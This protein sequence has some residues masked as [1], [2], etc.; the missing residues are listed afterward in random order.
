MEDKWTDLVHHAVDYLLFFCD[1]IIHTSIFSNAN[2]NCGATGKDYDIS[3]L[4]RKQQLQYVENIGIPSDS[5][6]KRMSL[7]SPLGCS[8]VL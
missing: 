6:L 2:S 7:Y 5:Y 4:S 1:P 3:R 8:V